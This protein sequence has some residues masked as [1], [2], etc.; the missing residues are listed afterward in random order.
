MKLEKKMKHVQ[1]AMCFYDKDTE[2]GEM[3]LNLIEKA[4]NYSEVESA[5]P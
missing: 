4:Y 2:P 5:L 1:S 3:E